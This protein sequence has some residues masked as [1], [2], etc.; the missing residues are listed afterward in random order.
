M[1][2][3]AEKAAEAHINKLQREHPDT[4]HSALR[5]KR[6]FLA[7]Y[8]AAQTW[9]SIETAPRDGTRV[10]IKVGKNW[11]VFASFRIVDLIEPP[12][13]EDLHHYKKEWRDDNGA[14]RTP[15]GW[16]PLPPSE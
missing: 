7:G 14:V 4:Y 5:V 10:A 9:R 13:E 8:S 12:R 11:A 1:S 6:D 3:E 16:L 2:D 15:T